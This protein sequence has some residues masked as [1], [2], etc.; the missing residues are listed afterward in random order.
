MFVSRFRCS[1]RP[2]PSIPSIRFSA[3]PG[4]RAMSSHYTLDSYLV[5]PSELNAALQKNVF[6]KLST[7]PRVIPL[8]AS[9]FL[10]N[11]GRDGY[12]TFIA[13]RIPHARF[14]DV[15]AIKDPHSPFP[16][17]LPSPSDFADAM[18]RLGIQRE[19]SVVVYDSKELGILSAPRVGWTLKAFGHPN[20]H[21]LNNFRKWVDEGFPTESGEPKEVPK[22]TYEVPALDEGK[23]VAFEEVRDIAKELGKEG[24]EEV[25]ILDAR[26]LGRW[27]GVDPEPREG[28]SS[29]HIPYSISVPI[30]DLLDPNDKT[31]L[32]AAE[33]QALFKSKGV[34]PS[35][36]IISSCGSGVT[37]AVIDAALTE[38]GFPTQQRRLYDGSWTEW[39]QRVKPG[40]GLIRKSE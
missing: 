33:L 28:L 13:Q 1:L 10:P 6:S 40:D 7:A 39:A 19:D 20:V 24:A 21:I 31:L 22:V 29:G 27:K 9:W 2:F 14:F 8:C 11:D 12:E 30:S 3:T 32:P 34:D 16:H 35:K 18:R 15:D 25:Q 36:P 5:S 17:M 23:V 37:A 38:A 4:R 26:S